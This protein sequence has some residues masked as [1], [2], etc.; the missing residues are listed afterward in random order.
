MQ[1]VQAVRHESCALCKIDTVIR[2]FAGRRP[3]YIRGISMRAATQPLPTVAQST[4]SRFHIIVTCVIAA[5][6]G[7]LFGLD[8]G[9]ISGALPFIAKTFGVGDQMQ[10]WIVSSMMIGAAVGALASG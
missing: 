4:G 5:L 8:I 3:I 7:L 1:K 9:V 2:S 6:A 10:E